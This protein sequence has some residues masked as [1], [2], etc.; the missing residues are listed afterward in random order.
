L[1]FLRFLGPVRAFMAEEHAK[2][3]SDDAE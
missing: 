1:I 2:D 3:Y